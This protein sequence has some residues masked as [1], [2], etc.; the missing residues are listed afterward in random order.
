MEKIELL[1]PAGSLEKLKIALLYGADAVYFGGREYSLRAN[2][3]NLSIEEI[4]EA[5]EYAHMLGKKVYVTVNIVFHNED[6]DGLKD[7]LFKLKECGVDAIIISDPLVLSI[8]HENNIDIPVH[9]STQ[10]SNVNYEAVSFWKD[11]GATRVVLGRETSKEEIKTIIDKTGLDIEIFNHGA[12]CSSYS[13]RCVLSNYFTNR[14]A[15]RGGCAQICRWTFDM[16]KD[17]EK[18]D[19]P[20]KFTMCS[21]DLCMI[22]HIPEII[23]IGVC[24]LKVEGR[25]RSIYYIATVIST[26]RKAIDDYYSGVLT[27]EKM[28]YYIK[29]L[30]RVANRDSC[31]QFFSRFPD[32]EEQYFLGR[33]EV[34]NQDYLGLVEKYE[35]GYAYIRVK[36]YFKSGEEVEIISPYRDTISFVVP[37]IYSEDGEVLECARHP[38]EIVKFKL[39]KEVS[40]LDMMRIMVK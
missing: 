20:V 37:T 34:S 12:M 2:A 33:E 35:D 24:S 32:K 14:D 22:R 10:Y 39:D 7:Y 15:N 40:S 38:E 25:M 27:N 21:K 26:Y 30:N 19:N 9:I 28:E 1:S 13:G 11:M 5:C 16:V 17:G 8:V 23:D 6:V 3:K 31:P 4:K 18:I 29:I 36:N